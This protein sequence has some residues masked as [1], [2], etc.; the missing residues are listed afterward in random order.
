MKERVAIGALIIIGALPEEKV[1]SPVLVTW[2]ALY[3]RVVMYLTVNAN[4]KMDLEDGNVTNAK[5][6]TTEIRKSNAF[7]AIAIPEFQNRCN[8]IVLLENVSV[9]KVIFNHLFIIL[10]V[11]SI[12]FTGLASA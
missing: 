4:A 2:S 10:K 5:R 6:I 3:Q 9:V 7:L 11:Q 1:V 12:L 8:A